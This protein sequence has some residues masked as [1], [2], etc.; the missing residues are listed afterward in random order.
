MDRNVT[1]NRL[2]NDIM[3]N[4]SPVTILLSSS[5][6]DSIDFVSDLANCYKTTFWIN[7]END[8]M[9]SFTIT[10]AQKVFGND[11][12]MLRKLMQFKYCELEYNKENII[13]NV[14]LQKISTL[15]GDCLLVMDN[16]ELLPKGEINSLIELL[17]KN[18]PKNLKILLIS[19]T[20]LNLNYNLFEP[21]CPK[22]IDELM[23]TKEKLYDLSIIDQTSLSKDDLAFLSYIS[24]LRHC[25][26]KLVHDIYPSGNEILTMLNIKYKNLVFCKGSELY[27]INPELNK[28]LLERFPEL[29]SHSLYSE[30]IFLRQYRHFRAENKIVKAIRIAICNKWYDLA[31][32]SLKQLITAPLIKFTLYDFGN[33]IQPDIIRKHD[34]SK[35]FYCRFLHCLAEYYY[36]NFELALNMVNELILEAEPASQALYDLHYIKIRC[37]SAMGYHQEAADLCYGALKK[38]VCEGDKSSVYKL[39]SLLGYIPQLFR[40]TNRVLDINKLKKFEEMMTGEVY[41]DCYWYP[42]IIQAGAEVYFDLGYYSKAIAKVEQLKEI[43]PFYVLPHKLIDYY[44]YSGDVEKYIK[45]AEICLENSKLYN[46]DGDLASVYG[47]LAKGCMYYEKYDKALEYMELAVTCENSSE[48]VKYY[49]IALRAIMHVKMGKIAYAKDLATIYAKI[50]ELNHPKFTY[51]FYAVLAFCSW[52]NKDCEQTKYYAN[53]CLQT[54]SAKSGT[55]FLAS[56]MSLSC[57]ISRGEIRDSKTLLTKFLNSCKTFSMESIILDYY[58]C[59]EIPF[60]KAKEEGIMLDYIKEID[61][62]IEAKR[63][64]IYQENKI[65]VKFFGNTEVSVN[66]EQIVW[67]TKKTKELF[68]LLVWAGDAGIERKTIIDLL[69][70]DYVYVSSLNNLKTTNNLIRNTLQAYNVPFKLE[71]INS[72]YTLSLPNCESD[73]EVFYQTMKDYSENTTTKERADQMR[74]ALI[75]YDVGFAIEITNTQFVEIRKAMQSEMFIRCFKLIE[76]LISIGEYLE[77]KRFLNYLERIGPADE[78]YS[79]LQNEIDNNIRKRF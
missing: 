35:N 2:I 79:K 76:D 56:A 60:T 54:A 71:Y 42:K 68:L 51:Y 47:L 33:N 6:G 14:A 43:F 75:Y 50:C 36:C 48:Q 21:N 57:I 4:S 38:E 17:I 39:Q 61:S 25:D 69:W 7:A 3:S 78:D 73:Y 9:Y 62:R 64:A 59:F 8:N 28:Y 23:L 49:S 77:A 70:Q 34:F 10:L 18:C 52:K 29:K 40:N 32:D 41:E 22:L 24:Q 26:R 16:L 65:Y 72:R 1:N 19:E 37:L 45:D 27:W 67:K 20:F 30:N 5:D 15:S 31:D 13:L 46:I 55:W 66:N 44:Y 63:K 53:K 74:K 58:D 11:S 12:V